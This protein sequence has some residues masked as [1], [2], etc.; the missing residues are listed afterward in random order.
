MSSRSSLSVGLLCGFL[1]PLSGFAKGSTWQRIQVE[2][3]KGEA[4]EARGDRGGFAK[5]VTKIQAWF[6]GAIRE[7]LPRSDETGRDVLDL[8]GSLVDHSLQNDG[9]EP[10]AGFRGLMPSLLALGEARAT[11]RNRRR[12]LRRWDRT[13]EALLHALRED[14]ARA[15]PLLDQLAQKVQK[16][17]RGSPVAKAH[18]RLRILR[19]YSEALPPG[20]FLARARL[21]A[22]ARKIYQE[23]LSSLGG[24]ESQQE[25]EEF[26]EVA[27]ELSLGEAVDSERD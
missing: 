16:E 9:A 10:V 19:A 27:M 25:R 6:P 18:L 23:G 5:A 8:F 7:E 17:L 4:A 13:L 3:S 22:Q 15:K 24:G 26:V 1:I 12:A 20:D 14:P 21:L 2:V 11:K